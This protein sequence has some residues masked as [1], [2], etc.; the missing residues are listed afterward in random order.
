MLLNLIDTSLKTQ[1]E[2]TCQ[3]NV[4]DTS[5]CINYRMYKT[6]YC[7]EKFFEVLSPHSS[8]NNLYQ[9]STVLEIPTPSRSVLL[10]V[11]LMKPNCLN[12]VVFKDRP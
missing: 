9:L 10:C 3:S 7:L 2:Q 8:E 12:D 11:K 5:K 4:N 1:F 6:E